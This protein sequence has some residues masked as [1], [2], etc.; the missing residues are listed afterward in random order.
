MEKTEGRKADLENEQISATR[1][2]KMEPECSKWLR[3]TSKKGPMSQQWRHLG[4]GRHL[5]KQKRP[6]RGPWEGQMGPQTPIGDDKEANK[7]P[8]WVQKGVRKGSKSE[9]LEKLKI[10][11]SPG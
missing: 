7:G 9:T 6:Q 8:T 5:K 2:P 4:N 11:L 1:T 3:R 10:K